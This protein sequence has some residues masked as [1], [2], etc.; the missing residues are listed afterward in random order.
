M[1][2]RGA[3]DDATA[4]VGEG[5]PDVDSAAV[6]VDV[7]DAQGGGF[8]PAQAG[9]GQKQDEQTPASCLGCGRIGPILDAKMAEQV[10]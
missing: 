10:I 8:A 4:D 6:E 2:F 3:E 5:A 9:V 1:R 7:A